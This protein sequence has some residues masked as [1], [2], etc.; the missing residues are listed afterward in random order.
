MQYE[1]LMEVVFLQYTVLTACVLL[2]AAAFRG[3]R[4]LGYRLLSGALCGGILG[5]IGLVISIR[6]H[7]MLL[8]VLFIGV[9]FLLSAV[10][11]PIVSR[12]NYRKNNLAVLVSIFMVGGISIIM[13][14]R[15]YILKH[16]FFF[17]LVMIASAVLTAYAVRKI[18][19]KRCQIYPVT[20][21]W[22][23]EVKSVRALA[24]S[25]NR[26]ADTQGRSVCVCSQDIFTSD[27]TGVTMYCIRTL[28]K[29]TKE[30]KGGIVEKMIVHTREGNFVYQNVPAVI[31]PGHVSA[32]GEFEMILHSNYCIRE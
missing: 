29:E 27:F 32:S 15:L 22:N 9:V 7:S 6:L 11:F 18:K 19:V 31:Y 26:I 13:N 24:D 23:G 14:R 17:A 12:Q 1:I 30:M 3:L 8:C 2:T 25:G 20:L 21:Y 16:V 4:I 28:G 5:C 10:A